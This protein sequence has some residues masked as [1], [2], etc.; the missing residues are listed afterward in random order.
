MEGGNIKNLGLPE[1]RGCDGGVVR[2]ST[3]KWGNSGKDRGVVKKMLK[4]RDG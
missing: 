4:I 2:D 3:L 1:V